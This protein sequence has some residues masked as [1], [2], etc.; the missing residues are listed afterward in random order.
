MAPTWYAMVS[1]EVRPSG[2]ADLQLQ[3][4]GD[5][6]VRT[7]EFRNLIADLPRP[8]LALNCV[9]GE[10]ATEMARLLTY[11]LLIYQSFEAVLHF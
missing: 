6:Y 4:V 3:V 2:S 7:L 5:D 1:L 8:K 11:I 9:G 10:T